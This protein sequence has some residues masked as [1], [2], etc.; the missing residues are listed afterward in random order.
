[1]F[2]Y[3]EGMYEELNGNPN[4]S[5]NLRTC[6]LKVIRKSNYD[7]LC[8]PIIHEIKKLQGGESKVFEHYIE[9]DKMECTHLK[10][11]NFF[12]N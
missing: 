8:V 10:V 3:W 11:A 4:T 2:D 12:L 9:K 7:V 5:K 6:F 1:M